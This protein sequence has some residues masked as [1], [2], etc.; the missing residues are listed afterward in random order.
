MW[1]VLFG[2]FSSDN[3]TRVCSASHCVSILLDEPLPL[4]CIFL[5]VVLSVVVMSAA[6]A[7]VTPG[8]LELCR[9]VDIGGSASM[10]LC[11]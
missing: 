9:S 6:V 4:A 11:F 10:G 8:W 1:L 5:T 7:F 3:L 2:F